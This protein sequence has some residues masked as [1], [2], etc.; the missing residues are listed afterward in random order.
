MAL[1]RLERERLRSRNAWS[2]GV[3]ALGAMA[4][5]FNHGSV[6]KEGWKEGGRGSYGPL[7]RYVNSAAGATA[8][9]V[10]P[11][12]VGQTR[13]LNNLRE[14]RV[15]ARS[16]QPLETGGLNKKSYIYDYL[17]KT[18]N[19]WNDAFAGK[20][21]KMP[22]VAPL[23]TANVASV[24]VMS[25]IG[26]VNEPNNRLIAGHELTQAVTTG[27][28]K[29]NDGV[30][31]GMVSTNDLIKGLT[32]AGFGAVGGYVAGRV[33]GTLFSQPPEVKSKLNAVGAIGGAIANLGIFK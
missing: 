23:S 28:V 32:R 22:Y 3:G 18:A 29:A 26:L 11:E 33:L 30:P 2:Y 25:S 20:D 10:S 19:E 27:L 6:I 4:P 1:E 13:I 21:F 14:N 12:S 9:A 17:E 16:E 5:L 7:S 24:P 31:A 8:A 15:S